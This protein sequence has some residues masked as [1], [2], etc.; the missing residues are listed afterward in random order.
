MPGDR[1]DSR[2]PRCAAGPAR[3]QPA[4]AAS[5]RRVIAPLKAARV[6]ETAVLRAK[7]TAVG[8]QHA[9]LR[10]ARR[11]AAAASRLGEERPPALVRALH[12]GIVRDLRSL[13]QGYARLGTTARRQ[14][15]DAYGQA[16]RP[17]RAAEEAARSVLA[18]LRDLGYRARPI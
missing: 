3:P 10:L 1:R 7:R 8:Q 9:A 15:R 2:P 14:Q 16:A 11:H 4:Y 12:A 6:R 17:V 5:L 13:A 18:R